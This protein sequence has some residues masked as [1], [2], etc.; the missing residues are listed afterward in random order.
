[1][2]TDKGKMGNDVRIFDNDDNAYLAWL[3]HYLDG[4][5]INTTRSRNASYMVLH[6][7]GC[8]HI[9]I[10]RKMVGPG[11]FTEREYIKICSINV[12]SL[13]KWVRE[14]GRRDGSFSS[15]CPCVEQENAY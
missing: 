7:A 2:T 12:E 1:M 5:V 9:S 14:N 6:R 8:P 13:R 10:P 15:E 4:F 3:D 11:G